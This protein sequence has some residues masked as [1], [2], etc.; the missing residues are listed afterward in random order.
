MLIG[1]INLTCYR[2]E[3]QPA[4]FAEGLVGARNVTRNISAAAKI[5]ADKCK[6]IDICR[7]A[8]GRFRNNPVETAD[9]QRA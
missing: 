1:A 9:R 6:I 2:V 5:N 3:L 8:A 7:T 4:S